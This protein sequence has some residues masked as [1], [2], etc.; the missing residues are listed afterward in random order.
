[1]SYV[2]YGAIELS[3]WIIFLIIIIIRIPP[4]NRS[5]LNIFMLSTLLLPLGFFFYKLKIL[6][7][8]K[9]KF[10]DL[11]NIEQSVAFNREN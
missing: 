7:S 10:K 2:I 8:L 11:L 6:Y 9:C 4:E 5:F 3:F 1:M